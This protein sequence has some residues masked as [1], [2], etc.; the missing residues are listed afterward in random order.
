MRFITKKIHAFLD[1]PVAIALMVLPFLLGLGG[2]NPLAIQTSVAVGAV[3]FILT[4]LTDHQ[5][6]A[7][8]VIPYKFH[9]IADF[10]VAVLFII[11]PFVLSFEGLDAL[12]YWV[13]GA[14]VLVVVGLHKPEIEG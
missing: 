11:V 8:K 3:A 4:L 13:I 6:G 10:L 1:Y 9:L 5:L 7:L 12:Y 2:S 14:T